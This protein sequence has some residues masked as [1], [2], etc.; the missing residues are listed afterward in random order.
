MTTTEIKASNLNKTAQDI[1]IKIFTR[2]RY[3]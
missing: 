1:A 3:G 2:R